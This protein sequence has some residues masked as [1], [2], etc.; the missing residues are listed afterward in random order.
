MCVCVR[1]R[2]KHEGDGE[3]EGQPWDERRLR[4][5]RRFSGVL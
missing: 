5:E 4:D 1:V 3:G 2:G